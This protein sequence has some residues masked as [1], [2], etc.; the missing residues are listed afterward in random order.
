MKR[1]PLDCCHLISLPT[2]NDTRGNLTFLEAEVHIPFSI[3]RI[4]YL[5]D[6]PHDSE[7]GSHAHKDLHQ[8]IIPI[9]G[10]F[11]ITLDD[12]HNTRSHHLDCA[13]TG[14]YICPMIW[15]TIKTFS[16]GAICLVLASNLYDE[17]DY[18]R[19]YHSFIAA[20]DPQ[21]SIWETPR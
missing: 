6:V 17:E 7:R 16:Q 4:Y 5:Y 9:S 13:S 1:S 18:Y 14:L 21:T 19:D 11:H 20:T 3:R 12:G 10:S 2:V 8:L 15:R